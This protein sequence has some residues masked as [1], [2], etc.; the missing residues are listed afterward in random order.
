MGAH[1]NHV[2]SQDNQVPPVEQIP[3]V[4]EVLIVPPLMTD[5]EIS[6]AFLNFAQAM[7]SKDNTMTSQVQS[8]TTQVNR[9]VRPQMPQHFSIMAS[10]LC[11][12]TRINPPMFFC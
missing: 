10:Q 6:M 11:D 1:D 3:M 12:F 2:P 5:G 4:G 8:M 7:A 9:E